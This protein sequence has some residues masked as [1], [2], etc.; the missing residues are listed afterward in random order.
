VLLLPGAFSPGG[1]AIFLGS[2]ITFGV[3]LRRFILLDSANLIT[4]LAHPSVLVPLMWR[5]SCHYIAGAT[6]EI[7]GYQFL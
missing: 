2:L 6:A 4:K 3:Q 5:L 7:N 1:S